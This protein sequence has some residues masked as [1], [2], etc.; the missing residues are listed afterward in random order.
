MLEKMKHLVRDMD[1]EIMGAHH[2]AKLAKKSRESDPDLSR[3]YGTM[4]KQELSHAEMLMEQARRVC[5]VATAEDNK[6]GLDAIMEIQE[7]RTGPWM[8]K[9]KGLLDGV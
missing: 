8:S 4:A 7:D 5:A 1:E 9:V 6:A 2:Y 3:M